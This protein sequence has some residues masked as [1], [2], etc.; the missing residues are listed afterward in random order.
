[1]FVVC[2]LV[3]LASSRIYIYELYFAKPLPFV[4]HNDNKRNYRKNLKHTFVIRSAIDNWLLGCL[5]LALTW[6]RKGETAGWESE[7]YVCI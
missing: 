4:S 5:C 1:M 7:V 6:L 2:A 3:L